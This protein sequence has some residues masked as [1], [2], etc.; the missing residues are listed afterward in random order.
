MS[1][2]ERVVEKA[3]EEEEVEKIRPA[4]PLLEY[5]N[6]ANDILTSDFV[7]QKEHENVELENFKKEYQINTLPDQI[8]KG[9]VT[10]VLEFYFGVRNQNFLQ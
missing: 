1:E 7:W 2:I 5:F 8:N 10:E 4:D 9:Q 6:K 3:K